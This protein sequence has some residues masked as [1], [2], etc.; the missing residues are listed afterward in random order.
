MTTNE[1]IIESIELLESILSDLLFIILP[2]MLLIFAIKLFTILVTHG[3]SSCYSITSDT[4]LEDKSSDHED[5]K[6]S[7][8]IS[9]DSQNLFT[10]YYKH[11]DD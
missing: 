7:N 9:A 10:K 2:V 8:P 11:Y 6:L 4:D 5:V 3:H 1:L